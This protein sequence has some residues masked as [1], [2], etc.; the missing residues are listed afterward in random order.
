[1]FSMFISS[2]VFCH[3][4]CERITFNQ[5]TPNY[6][7]RVILAGRGK[8]HGRYDGSFQYHVARSIL[9]IGRAADITVS[10]HLQGVN[11]Q[12]KN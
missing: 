5:I 8:K 3:E 4:C 9:N 2:F 7:R 1:M 12:R 6:T 10:T 11:L